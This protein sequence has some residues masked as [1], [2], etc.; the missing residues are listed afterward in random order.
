MTIRRIEAT[1]RDLPG[2]ATSIWPGG[3]AT[4]AAGALTAN[5]IVRVEY[6][7]TA[8]TADLAAALDRVRSRILQLEG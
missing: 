6:E 4:S 1:A 2:T 5:F 7:D 3:M 8:S